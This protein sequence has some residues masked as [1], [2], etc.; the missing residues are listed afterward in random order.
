MLYKYK[1]M[2]HSLDAPNHTPRP[3]EY[4]L[5]DNKKVSWTI[6]PNPKLVVDKPVYTYL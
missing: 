3:K 6:L 5:Q 1:D 4:T 2:I